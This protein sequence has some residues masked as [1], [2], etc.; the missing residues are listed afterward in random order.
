M[1]KVLLLGVCLV[2]L[3]AAFFCVQAVALAE[4]TVTQQ[5]VT[6]D[7][8]ELGEILAVSAYRNT[9]AVLRS[10]DGVSYLT[11]MGD[12]RA[13]FT[14]DIA[15]ADLSAVHFAYYDG[16][17][18]LSEGE[19]LTAYD[20]ATGSRRATNVRMKLVTTDDFGEQI[21]TPLT[22]F[23]VDERGRV[24]VC[25]GLTILRWMEFA[26]LF[27]AGK[28]EIYS[29]YL[30]QVY[31]AFSA[32]C[33]VCYF[34]ST[35]GSVYTVD[36]GS[37]AAVIGVPRSVEAFD[38]YDY[39][40]E[41]AFL[42]GGEIR[43][44]G[45]VA[46]AGAGETAGDRYLLQ[47]DAFCTSF[48]GTTWRAFV[49]DNGQSAV[50]VYDCEWRYVGMYGADGVDDGRLKAPTQVAHDEMVA[51]LD[52]GNHRVVMWRDGVYSDIEG[53]YVSV[54]THGQRV[55]VAENDTIACYDYGRPT[56]SAPYTLKEYYLPA[57]VVSICCDGNTLYA[58]TAEAMFF[59]RTE[60]DPFDRQSVSALQTKVGRHPGIVYVRT[61][62]AIIPYKDREAV[63][64]SVDVSALDVVDFDVDYCGNVYVLTA[65]GALRRYARTADGYEASLLTLDRPLTS[66][67]IDA[68]GVVY[69]LY[70]SALVRVDL[71]VR[72]RE[73]SAYPEPAWSDPV[74]VVHVHQSVWGYAAPN[75]FESLV[76]V[77]QDTYGMLMASHT[78]QD[79][80]YYYIEF[81]LVTSGTVRY[82]KV[83]VPQSDATVVGS[84]LADDAYVRYD[85][86]SAETGLYAHPSYS[87]A[88]VRMLAKADAVLEVLAV[89][90]VEQGAVVWPWYRVR[91]DG[92]VYYVAIDNYVS[93]EPPYEEVKRYY[94]RCVAN[95]IGEKVAVYA[96]P[97]ADAEVLTTLVD[98]T[99]VELTTP[100]DASSEYTCIRIGDAE[101]YILTANVTTR[102][103]TNG[104][105]FALIMSI[106]VMVAAA[107]TLVLYLLVQRKH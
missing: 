14:L 26:Q 36:T 5:Y 40:G 86:A 64:V 46:V 92:A 77:P 13:E 41:D 99:K 67:S 54:A 22:Y 81:A 63:G 17:A 52:A 90:G 27:V 88:A 57:A 93:A 100:F 28:P 31:T 48:D 73:D 70:H 55:Y 39:M 74:S 87:A 49:A 37:G 7:Y 42:R 83:Y 20:C 16:V 24:Y 80:T 32:H 59:L 68:D 51:V 105:T 47:A 10:K 21:E 53:D 104:Q 29:T 76:R 103:M 60:T 102:A 12:V 78:Y 43:L 15:P 65:D 6:A 72:T 61:T 23:A 9:V 19:T 101:A 66:L 85:G 30:S 11:V 79:N 91:Y 25:Y 45:S 50:K 84:A 4:D 44:S 18:L 38:D 82:E 2:V 56:E 58:L 34:Y 98:G 1:K 71:V 97:A 89:M 33:G 107:V 106:I 96:A 8:Y 95:K 75:N 69:G 3:A 94:A 35:T 62:T